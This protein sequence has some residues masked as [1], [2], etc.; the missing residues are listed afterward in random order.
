MVGKAQSELL[1]TVVLIG[2]ALVIGIAMISLVGSTVSSYREQALLINTLNS[3]I[4]N[5][6]V[7]LV[8]Y[9]DTRGRLWLLLKRLDGSRADFFIAIAADT[10]YLQCSSIQYFNPAADTN[11]VMCDESGDCPSAQQFRLGDPNKI[12]VPYGGSITTLANFIRAR[13]YGIST[14]SYVPICIV[15]NVCNLASIPGLCTS[16]TIFRVSLPIGV[17]MVRVFIF[18]LFSD[19]L[20]LVNVY[21][22]RIS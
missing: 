8:T 10:Q 15:R 21:E 22:V 5:T 2:L 19:N 1:T 11:G 18:T 17:K 13:G 16:N 20:Y 6:F 14:A 3:E 7:N 9:D 12:Y 4:S